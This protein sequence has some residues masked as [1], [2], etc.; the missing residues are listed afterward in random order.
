MQ[1]RLDSWQLRS[2]IM[3]IADV[4]IVAS[5]KYVLTVI[6]YYCLRIQCVSVDMFEVSQKQLMILTAFSNR[7]QMLTH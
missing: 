1:I 4:Q 7:A 2:F 6:N 5:Q 3:I